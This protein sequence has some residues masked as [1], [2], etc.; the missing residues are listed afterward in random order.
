MKPPKCRLCGSPHWNNEPHQFEKG[1][2]ALANASFDATN[3]ATNKVA[4]NNADAGVDP[5]AGGTVVQGGPVLGSVGGDGVVVKVRSANRRSRDSYNAYQREYMR[6]R[7][8]TD[9]PGV[10]E[11][12]PRPAVQDVPGVQVVGEDSRTK[13]S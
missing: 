6:K 5:R 1:A 10:S 12:M 8:G 3:S 11:D 13:D 2:K 7:R 4:T 9:L